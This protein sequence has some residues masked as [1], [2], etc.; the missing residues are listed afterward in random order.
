MTSSQ[1]KQVNA[2]HSELIVIGGGPAGLAAAVTAAKAG[3]RV[4]LIDGGDN[5]GGQYFRNSQAAHDVEH[6]EGWEAFTDLVNQF[7]TAR[8]ESALTYLSRTSV[9]S[10]SDL[11]GEFVVRARK[12]ERHPEPIELC[13]ERVILAT[14][15]H[16][17]ALPFEGWQLPGSMTIGG[18]QSLLK[19]SGAIA[20][21]AIVIAGTGPF[22]LATAA[23]LV[24][25]GAH[26]VAVVEA[27]RFTSM[28]KYP[29]ALI[30]ARGKLFQAISYLAILRKAKVQLI[31]NAHVVKAHAS[32][33]AV[34]TVDIQT[35]RGIK[36]LKCDTIATGWGFIPQLELATALGLSTK[37][38]A[39][40]V[41]VVEVDANQQSSHPRLWAAGETTGVAGSDAALAEGFIAGSSAAITAGHHA[42]DISRWRTLRKR[43][44]T[45]AHYLP[46]AYP[47]PAAWPAEIS[48][49]TMVC[50]CEEV[51]AGDVRQAIVDFGAEDARSAKLFSRVGM[52]WCQG[53]MCARACSDLIAHELGQQVTD[54]ELSGSAKRPIATPITL[55]MLA[56]WR[57]SETL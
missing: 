22:L 35:K 19:G 8:T 46:L 30:A 2:M 55:G 13:A 18:A 39:D 6:P 44:H 37:Q 36:T 32:N 38:T 1:L 11:N 34:S 28:S 16:D 52:G 42:V 54:N 9:W 40:G 10:I 45:F 17:R 53:R 21:N 48:D 23:G 49:D 7:E 20:G 51:T 31:E 26:V 50:R 41:L 14:G 25:A 15:A 27:N 47:I 3:M 29:R 24:K 5:L 12:G 33:G 4:A 57:P 43:L 56:D